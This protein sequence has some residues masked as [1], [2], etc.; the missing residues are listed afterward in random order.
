[1]LND[2]QYLEMKSA[3]DK[4]IKPDEDSIRYYLLCKNCARNIAISGLGTYTEDEEV[5]II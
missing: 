2:K 5:I 1:M 3:L 4:L